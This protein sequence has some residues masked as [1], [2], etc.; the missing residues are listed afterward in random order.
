MDNQN[1]NEPSETLFEGVKD[2]SITLRAQ[3]N[4]EAFLNMA[5]EL[6]DEVA[7][8]QEQPRRS[9]QPRPEPTLE[10]QPREVNTSELSS[11]KNIARPSG[12]NIGPKYMSALDSVLSIADIRSIEVE[13]PVLKTKAEVSPLTSEE[14]ISLRTAA[15]SPETFLKKVDELLFRHTTFIDREYDVYTDFLSDLYPPDK[16]LLIWALLTASYLVLPPMETVCEECE[17]SYIVEASPDQM[18]H[19]DTITQIWDKEVNANEYIET[20]KVLNGYITFE[21]SMP[22]ER[23][24]LVITKLLNPEK[25]KE[26][27]EKTGNIMTYM[28]NLMFF[29]KT[30]IV[31]EGN[32]KIVLMDV[33]QDIYPFLKN[34][35]PKISDAV[36]SEIDVTIFDEYM[37]SFYL[38]EECPKCKHINRLDIDPELVFFRKALSV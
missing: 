17:E 22:S 1:Y 34:I 5:D 20:Q 28:D 24:R 16:S 26:N 6:Q 25:A 9:R 37:P 12:S 23:D 7:Q 18:I 13:L 38:E 19:S 27:Y 11:L 32:D 15:V 21:L 30:I 14:E 4:A 3:K 2:P 8:P 33:I 35:P 29:A 10:Q 36:K 31:G